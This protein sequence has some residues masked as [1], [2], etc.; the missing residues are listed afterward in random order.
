MSTKAKLL[1]IYVGESMRYKG[2]PLYRALLFKLKDAGLAGVTVTRGV[3]GYGELK[4]VHTT[5][6]LE[7]SADLPMVIESVDA[8]DKV[9][10]VLPEISKMVERGLIF[11]ADVAVHK[12]TK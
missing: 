7:L 6:L 2:Q 12:W 5:R 8:A 3:E 1:K 4:T 10:A 9:N 11:T